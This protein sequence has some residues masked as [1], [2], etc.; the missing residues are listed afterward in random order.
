MALRFSTSRRS[1]IGLCGPRD[2]AS[3]QFYGDSARL[4]GKPERWLIAEIDQ[5]ASVFA[6]IL[7]LKK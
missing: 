4:A 7:P 6:G 3:L 5:R 1:C 2:K